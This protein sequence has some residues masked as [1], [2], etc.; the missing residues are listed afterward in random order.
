MKK[1]PNISEGVKSFAESTKSPIIITYEGIIVYYNTAVYDF[2]NINNHL[3]TNS[4]LTNL[5]TNDPS[6]KLTQY[7]FELILLKSKLSND[8]NISLNYLDKNGNNSKCLA[9]F[10]NFHDSGITLNLIYLKENSDLNTIKNENE[11]LK[12]QNILKSSF[13]ANMSHEI[14]TPLN[15][16]IGFSELLMEMDNTK[17]EEKLYKKMIS[18]SGRSLMQLIEDIIDISKIET[19]QLKITKAKFELNSFLDDL[20]V[21]FK[22]EKQ[23]RDLSHIDLKLSKAI[24]DRELYIY[25]D[26]TRLRQ[27]LSNLITNSLKFIDSGFINFGYILANDKHLQFYVID[28]GVGIDREARP[29]IFERFAQDKTTLKRNSEGTGLGLAISKSIINLLN[30][31]IWLDTEEGY[32]TTV[33]F[34]IP[35]DEGQNSSLTNSKLDKDTPPNYSNKTILIVDDVEPNIIYFNSLFK[36]TKAKII[37]ARSGREAIEKCKTN[38]SISIVLMDIMMPETDGFETTKI[39][40]THCPN[41]PIIMQ[42]AFSSDDSYEKSFEAGA[43]EFITKPIDPQ[44][45]FK[46]ID[47]Y[48]SN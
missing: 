43:S 2:L 42:T 7:D 35:I 14:R 37:I 19:G 33:Y 24:S 38:K 10:N 44:Q 36:P 9:S 28:T 31:K 26:Q 8:H 23:T 46:L 18:S 29:I 3:L 45:T 48:I 30:G 12:K 11:E 25:T 34:T 6:N 4:K 32:G 20:L 21:S 22:H 39:I 41:L 13:L 1:I 40:K 5:F 27:V 47:K 17:E 16:I 15:S